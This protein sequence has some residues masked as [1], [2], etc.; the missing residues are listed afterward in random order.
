M[1]ERVSGI[2]EMA[3][4]GRGR[5]IACAGILWGVVSLVLAGCMVGPDYTKPAPRVPAQFSE[6]P[7][8]SKVAGEH[9]DF[10]GWWQTFQDPVL[11]ALV[12][13]AVQ[14]NT[15]LKIAQ[16]R[17]REARALRT[18][19][20]A[21]EYPAVDASGAYTRIR[22]SENASNF[23]SSPWKDLFQ[24]GLDASWEVDIF[25]GTRRSVEAA[26]A[27]L[28][29][30][31]ENLRDVVVSLLAEVA[32]NYLDLRG[33]QRRITIARDNIEVQRQTLVLTRAKFQAGL[34]SELEIAQAEAQLSSTESRV[35]Q[36]ESA[37][38]R[39]I[40]RLG[41]LLGMEP[42]ALLDELSVAVELPVTPPEIPIGLPSDLLRRRP[43]VRRAERQLAAATARIGIATA[44]LFPRF[45]L[46]GSAGWQSYNASDLIS[47]HSQAF[48]FGPSIR[49][50]IFDAGRIRANIQVQNARQE[51][52]LVQYE[53]T[54]LTSLEDVENS[55]VSYSRE[56]VTRGYLSQAVDA[57]QR[58]VEI[59][60]ELYTQGLV[61]FLNVLVTQRNLFQLQEQLSLSEQ[62]VC[63]NLVALYKSLGGGWETQIP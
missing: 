5:R 44:D 56:Q 22:S 36:F 24:L 49:W 63:T 11:N 42:G 61:D 27:D 19:V 17:V 57:N 52:A 38:R 46:T 4:S 2:A 21:E 60:N 59:A 33:N 62:A 9:P 55:L 28:E 3:G 31:Q 39:A 37:S 43:D 51:Q 35:P 23:S 40:H 13:R 25:G 18:L 6:L 8:D 47:P 29:A 26:T 20:T 41:V 48:S 10:A 34:S 30:S 15:D 12:D 50:P 14:S 32:V 45:I 7:G 54:V 58:A 53:K 1:N 16:A